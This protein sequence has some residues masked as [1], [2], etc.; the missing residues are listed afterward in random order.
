[1]TLSAPI[2]EPP[3]ARH[4]LVV[5]TDRLWRERVADLLTLDGHRVSIAAGAAEAA[6]A[7][8]AF[9]PALVVVV[10]SRTSGEALSLLAALETTG[11]A[12]PAPA[13][14]VV[15]PRREEVD[16]LD[17]FAAG[18]DDFLAASSG[19]A[20]LLARARA[21]LRRLPE[22]IPSVLTCGTLRIDTAARAVTENGRAVHLSRLEYA[23][24]TH[25]AREPQ[26]V[27][28]KAELLA[29]VWGFRTPGATRTLDSHASR[30]RRKLGPGW[31]VNV[32]G[33]GYRLAATP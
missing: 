18:A 16:A 1:M 9:A 32:W 20:E 15:A 14:L 24:L 13:T 29:D 17:A 4:V 25:L 27:F 10:S 33:V 22:G 23:L 19:P 21:L 8:R 28:T 3:L 11:G 31:L 2:S 26:R 6:R 12:R 30:L 5:S 7:R